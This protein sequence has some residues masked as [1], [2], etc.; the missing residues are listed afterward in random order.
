MRTPWLFNALLS[1]LFAGATA[2]IARLGLSRIDSDLATLVRTVFVLAFL[3]LLYAFARPLGLSAGGGQF[4]AGLSGLTAR[5]TTFLALSALTTALSWLFYFR[6]LQAGPVASVAA[7]DKGSLLVTVALS[8]LILGEAA[9]P[10]MLGG[11]L[12][13]TAGLLLMTM[14]P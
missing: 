8:V 4:A 14:H 11:A 6:A 13:I 5:T 1:A 7:I 12:L 2:V 9:G 3:A 10:R